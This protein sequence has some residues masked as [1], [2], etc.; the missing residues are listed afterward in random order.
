[1]RD[2]GYRIWLA[3]WIRTTHAGPAIFSG[4]LADTVQLFAPKPASSAE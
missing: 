4:T 1:V 3:P 2:A